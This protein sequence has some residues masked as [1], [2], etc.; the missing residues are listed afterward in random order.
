MLRS[1]IHNFK[2]TESWEDKVSNTSKL[3]DSKLTLPPHSKFTVAVGGPFESKVAYLHITV[4]VGV[5]LES[6]A[7]TH[8]LL[9]AP[10][11]EEY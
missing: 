5:P 9:E 4:A 1:V 7:L 10:L 3:S 2:D 6:K 8:M 11:Q